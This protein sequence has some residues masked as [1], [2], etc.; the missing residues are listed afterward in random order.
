MA[1]FEINKNKRIN[2]TNFNVSD[3][4][5]RATGARIYDFVVV[6]APG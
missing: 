6:S 2:H 5:C 4:Y 1:T 3:V